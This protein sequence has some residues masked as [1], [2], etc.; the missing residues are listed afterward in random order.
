MR[1]LLVH[2]PIQY[3]PIH[4]CLVHSEMDS[5]S[6]A[7]ATD[8]LATMLKEIIAIAQQI[9]RSFAKV[10][11]SPDDEKPITDFFFPFPAG[12]S[13]SSDCAKTV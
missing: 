10:S 8:N 13:E 2:F 1:P 7:L 12:F 3:Q 5:L 4:N 9:E 6:I 11:A